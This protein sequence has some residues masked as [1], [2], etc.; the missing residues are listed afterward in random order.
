[1]TSGGACQRE[2]DSS[3][4]GRFLAVVALLFARFLTV[5]TVVAPALVCF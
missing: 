2:K 5:V 1:M 4:G 3:P